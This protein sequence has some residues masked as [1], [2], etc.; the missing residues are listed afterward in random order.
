[1]WLVALL[2]IASFFLFRWANHLWAGLDGIALMHQY[3]TPVIWCFF[4]G[5]AALS[6]PWPFTVWLLRHMGRKDEA[7][8]ITSES[9][10]TGQVD[11]FRVL[12]WMS[13]CVAGPIFGFTLLAI[14]LHL[15]VTDTAVIVG[16][17]AQWHS[18]RFQLSAARRMTLVQGTRYRD[19]TFHPQEDLI[20]DF[21]DGRQL[22]ANVVGDGGSSVP[23]ELLRLLEEKIQLPVERAQALEDIPKL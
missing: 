17:Y 6:I 22:N 21:A 5:F 20:I 23:P 18:E 10:R 14:P 1:M 9:N 12:T 13:I 15:T 4:P 8:S 19:G 2:L 16:H 11:S 7:D 3:A